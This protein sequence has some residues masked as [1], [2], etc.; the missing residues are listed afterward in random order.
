MGRRE[1]A[2]LDM[3]IARPSEIEEEGQQEWVVMVIYCERDK[4]IVPCRTLES[5]YTKSTKKKQLF[6]LQL[7][8]YNHRMN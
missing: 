5:W 7:F 6:S 8:S 2:G 3:I 1:Q 4:R